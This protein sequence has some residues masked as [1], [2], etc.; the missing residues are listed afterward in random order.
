MTLAH[1]LLHTQIANTQPHAHMPTYTLHAYAE[2]TQTKLY[3]C[4]WS[5]QKSL[6]VSRCLHSA[7]RTSDVRS[8][9]AVNIGIESTHTRID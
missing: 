3:G 2:L 8:T 7:P 4:S 9:P 6:N 1:A 5:K